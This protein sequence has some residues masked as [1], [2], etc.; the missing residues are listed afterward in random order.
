MTGPYPATV[1]DIDGLN[2]VFRRSFTQR[3]HKDGLVGVTVPNLTRKTWEFAL[4]DTSGGTVL[5]RGENNEP[6]AFIMARNSGKEG[7]IGPGGILPEYQGSGRGV[8]LIQTATDCVKSRHVRIIGLE[9]MPRAVDVIGLY[10]SLGYVLERPAVTV[11]IRSAPAA[12]AVYRLNTLPA[13]DRD[14]VIAQC[15]MLVSELAPGYDYTREITLTHSLGVGDTI[16]LERVGTVHAFAICH[17]TPVLEGHAT[18]E[19]R[20]LKLVARTVDDADA[21]VTSLT[22][23]A[24]SLGMPRVAI[25]LQGEYVELY[26]TMI[27]RGARFQR[28]D[29]RM[30][31]GGVVDAQRGAGIVLS[32]WEI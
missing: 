3:Y 11:T 2:A 32:S 9:T 4:Q 8:T 21:L 7:W 10:S 24:Y 14:E 29:M 28:T 5:W 1:A 23:F 22:G 18:E 30:S 12:D 19:V 31:Y 6:V 13:R 27:A 15:S 25:K 16:V 20:V 26:R 17:T